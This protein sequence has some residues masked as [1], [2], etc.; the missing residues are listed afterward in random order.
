MTFSSVKF[1]PHLDEVRIVVVADHFAALDEEYPTGRDVLRNRKLVESFDIREDVV[2]AVME[3]VPA[4]ADS[5]KATDVSSNP[6]NV[7]LVTLPL[8]RCFSFADPTA[9]PRPRL[10]CS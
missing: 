5:R 6:R 3:E 10:L 7:S 1:E 2:V 8:L 4:R 9:L